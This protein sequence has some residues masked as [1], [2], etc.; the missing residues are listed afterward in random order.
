M[1]FFQEITQWDQAVPNHTYL[2]NDSKSRMSGYVPANANHLIMF[3]Q[4]MPFDTRGRRFREVPD[5][6]GHIPSEPERS[7]KFTGSRGDEYVVVL[8]DGQPMCS[9]PGYQFRGKCKHVT[10]VSDQLCKEMS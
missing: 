9:C 1:K 2:L 8:S 3:S 7:W 5:Q 6:W 10:E 4:P